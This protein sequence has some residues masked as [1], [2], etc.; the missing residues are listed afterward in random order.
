MARVSSTR[1]ASS[2]RCA[3]TWAGTTPSTSSSGPRCSPDAFRSTTALLMLSGRA[4][5]ELVQKA[6]MAGV[7][8]VAAVGAPSTL[9]VELAREAG[10]TLLGFVRDARFNVYCGAERIVERASRG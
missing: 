2:T 6:A 10:I 4:S 8:I 1:R 5:F 3:R 9:A 7:P